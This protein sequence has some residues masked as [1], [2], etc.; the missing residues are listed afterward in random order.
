MKKCWI[1]FS[2]ETED[3]IETSAW[4]SPC[5][6]A[7]VAHEDCLLDW[8]A[9][10]E[11]PSSQKRTIGAPQLQ[12]PQCKSE[13]HLARP[14]DVLVDAVRTTERLSAKLVTPA[15]LTVA[16]STVV[17]ACTLHGVHSIFMIFGQEDGWRIL[18][19]LLGPERWS[20]PWDPR[21]L[22]V[23]A[24][25][26]W[27]L[28]LGLPLIT[29]ML[30]LS[31]THFADSVLPVLPII[32]FA[33][34]ADSDQPLS[35]GHWP[36]SASMTIAVLPYLRGLYNAYYQ[37]VWAAHEKRWLKD[38]QPRQSQAAGT[39]EDGDNAARDEAGDE[40]DAVAED[41][42][43][44]FELRM[45]AN[46]WDWE[47]ADVEEQNL[48]MQERGRAQQERDGAEEEAEVIRQD[49]FANGAV[50]GLAEGGEQEGD[51]RGVGAE[52]QA[53]ALQAP[54]LADN[55]PGVAE[56]PDVLRQLAQPEEPRQQQQEQARPQPQPQP[57]PQPADRRISFTT[58]GLAQKVLGAI[59]FPT[60]ASLTGE[61]LRLI[62]PLS[63]T[64]AAIASRSSS[65]SFWRFGTGGS[66]LRSR[67]TGLLQER[68]GRSVV[69]GCLF[70]VVKDAV[71]LYVRWK[72]A[73]QHRRRRVLDY[74]RS[75]G[76][77]VGR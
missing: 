8:I 41:E 31:R 55:E 6:C 77:V 36:P 63:W 69:G 50:P 48:P 27:R 51:E 26:H 72:M 43:G 20:K 56:A 58:T 10:M 19:P 46:I 73:Q 7:L 16:L 39:N 15:A 64:T 59:L 49:M 75:K 3:T 71:M 53:P 37:R 5:P 57:Q 30:V 61:A 24:L 17:Q 42:Q 45:D 2:D 12:C 14:R 1:C 4:R 67:T 65:S 38:I 23:D 60:I 22:V 35:L 13:I 9:D 29:P 54:P 21:A 47:G 44:I 76:R 66:G 52:E 62:L 70:V 11:S 32:F 25:R 74:D 33:T 18:E 28:N 68:W 34:Q 40:G